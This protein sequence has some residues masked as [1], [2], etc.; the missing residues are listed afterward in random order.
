MY[1][2]GRLTLYKVFNV[3]PK[4]NDR[5][6]DVLFHSRCL[7]FHANEKIIILKLALSEKDVHKD[8]LLFKI[9]YAFDKDQTT[10]FIT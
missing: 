3:S 9:N 4:S 10:R 7:D 2:K 6:T 8:R 5:L 1:I